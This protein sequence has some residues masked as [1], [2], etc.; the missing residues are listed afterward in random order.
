MIDKAVLMSKN[1]ITDEME[2]FL[3]AM[4]L[5]V[6]RPN[7]MESLQVVYNAVVSANVELDRELARINTYA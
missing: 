1:Q 4:V 3:S 5:L 7:N 6:N 2:K